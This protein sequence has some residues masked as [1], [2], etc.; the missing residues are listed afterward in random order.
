M[1]S[2]TASYNHS[3]CAKQPWLCQPFNRIL[4]LIVW[5]SLFFLVTFFIV[6]WVKAEGYEYSSAVSESAE[7]IAAPSVSSYCDFL[8]ETAVVDL[9]HRYDDKMTTE[10]GSACI[11][12][13]GTSGDYHYDVII[14]KENVPITFISM[15]DAIQYGDWKN[16]TFLAEAPNFLCCRATGNVDPELKSNN[17][18]FYFAPVANNPLPQIFSQSADSWIGYIGAAMVFFSLGQATREAAERVS[19]REHEVRTIE[20]SHETAASMIFDEK[21]AGSKK[22]D[23]DPGHISRDVP[24]KP[25]SALASKAL[26]MVLNHFAISL[27]P[28][29]QNLQSQLAKIDPEFL[30]AFH[31]HVNNFKI[32]L[33]ENLPLA[34]AYK[35]LIEDIQRGLNASIKKNAVVNAAQIMERDAWDNVVKLTK[36]IVPLKAQLIEA[37]ATKNKKELEHL[38]AVVKIYEGIV[39][40]RFRAA[41]ALQEGKAALAHR[42]IANDLEEIFEQ[43]EHY[44]TLQ[45][46]AQQSN[47]PFA[48]LYQAIIKTY[49]DI[50]RCRQESAPA[51][52]QEEASSQLSQAWIAVEQCYRKALEHRKR[53]AQHLERHPEQR[54]YGVIE[55]IAATLDKT[56]GYQRE[57]ARAIKVGDLPEAKQCK[58]TAQGYEKYAQIQTLIIRPNNLHLHE[59]WILECAYGDL[60]K[61]RAL[62]NKVLSPPNTDGIREWKGRQSFDFTERLAAL[63]PDLGRFDSDAKLFIKA[64]TS[65]PVVEVLNGIGEKRLPDHLIHDLQIMEKEADAEYQ[66]R[67]IL[68]G[69]EGTPELRQRISNLWK[70]AATGYRN[71]NY[72]KKDFYASFHYLL[73]A[74]WLE[75]HYLKAAEHAE[76]KGDCIIKAIKAIQTHDENL[77]ARYLAIASLRKQMQLDY[78]QL[79]NIRERLLPALQECEKVISLRVQAIEALQRGDAIEVITALDDQAEQLERPARAEMAAINQ[80][81]FYHVSLRHL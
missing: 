24:G 67:V 11:Q 25:P 73:K 37:S 4:A 66:S 35:N 38:G 12:R 1:H 55:K 29:L 9:E 8:N 3:S 50:L 36:K 7:G 54:S 78:S 33:E 22:L 75:N 53:L 48:A 42:L 46:S 59:D 6:S 18:L 41:D 51:V 79:G 13:S 77:A 74:S 26:A 45:A 64:F 44:R 70:E 21:G 2:S 49:G 69:K 39:S 5:R 15:L 20:I 76:Q 60:A 61:Q 81:L 16:K 56:A 10:L 57:A 23:S 63:F 17:L 47:K 43:I 80:F 27:D 68:R 58:E 34:L 72:S 19:P 14:G 32:V 65:A 62:L 40:L 31:V 28:Y 71:Y 30:G 52:G